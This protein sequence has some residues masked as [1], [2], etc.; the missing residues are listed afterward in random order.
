VSSDTFSENYW[1]KLGPTPTLAQGSLIKFPKIDSECGKG[2]FQ[3][4]KKFTIENNMGNAQTTKNA[5]MAKEELLELAWDFDLP[6]TCSAVKEILC[7]H[8][9]FN[10]QGLKKITESFK[11]V[12]SENCKRS[13]F[14]REKNCSSLVAFHATVE[15]RL[16]TILQHL[17]HFERN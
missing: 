8:R 14:Y 5:E 4:V 15:S 12:K 13:A 6:I 1:K 3:V 7:R 9:A 10:M 2:D 17:H 16:K 11:M